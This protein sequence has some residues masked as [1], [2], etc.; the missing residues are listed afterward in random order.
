MKSEVIDQMRKYN[1]I[2]FDMDGTIIDTESVWQE[3]N[4][5]F[6]MK[7][8]KDVDY[9]SQEYEE[10]RLAL[11][12]HG[13]Q[14]V[15]KRVKEKFGLMESTDELRAELKT[16]AR[17]LFSEKKINF[18]KGFERFHGEI[19]KIGIPTAI[20]TNAEDGDLQIIAQKTG[21]HAFFDTHIYGIIEKQ[22]R[23]KPEPDIYLYAAKKLGVDPKTCIAFEDS[24]CG[25]LSAIA[26]G[27]HCI[28]I[29]SS[30]KPHLLPH[31][32]KIVE[33]YDE[34]NIEEYFPSLIKNSKGNR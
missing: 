34:I 14:E 13:M 16:I 19:K 4:N 20:A 10:L 29:N 9:K 28:A 11:H 1:A 3:A 7:N 26:A 33:D 8:G 2:V 5:K 21:L 17:A 23:S 22:H 25:S 31:V 24:L 18:I 32:H 27:M 6:L 30:K 12:G 15:C